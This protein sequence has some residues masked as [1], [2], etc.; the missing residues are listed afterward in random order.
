[1]L[2]LRTMKML[3]A[4]PA[5]VFAAAFALPVWALPGPA[6]MSCCPADGAL[7]CCLVPD[8]CVL[9]SCDGSG[10]IPVPLTLSVFLLPPLET[11]AA[12]ADWVL[13]DQTPVRALQI[14]RPDLPDPPPRG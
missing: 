7:A 5:V 8:G 6:G 12:P 2:R 10:A 11:V 3:R 9:R 14:P 1:M 4:L 13:L